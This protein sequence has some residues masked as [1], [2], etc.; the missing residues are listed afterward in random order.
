MGASTVSSGW[1]NHFIEFMKILH[2]RIPLWLAYD[3]WTALRVAEKTI[4]RDMAHAADPSLVEGTQAFL[5]RVDA[6]ITA[7]SAELVQRAHDLV[8]ADRKSTRLNSSH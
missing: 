2:I 5:Q 4:A 3:H 8:G 1:S 7:H 6:L